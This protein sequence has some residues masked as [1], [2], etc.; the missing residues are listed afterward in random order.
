MDLYRFLRRCSFAHLSSATGYRGRTLGQK[1]S[2]TYGL[3]HVIFCEL[4]ATQARYDRLPDPGL[5]VGVV[6]VCDPNLLRLPEHTA[7]RWLKQDKSEV[8]MQ[9]SH[10]ESAYNA[11]QKECHFPGS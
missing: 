2:E 10:A 8:C 3:I 1:I 9:G 4:I 6:Q 11:S 7:S 5:A